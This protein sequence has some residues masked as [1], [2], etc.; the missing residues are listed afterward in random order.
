[1]ESAGARFNGMIYDNTFFLMLEL[2]PNLIKVSNWTG[3]SHVVKKMKTN[4]NLQ[5]SKAV[6]KVGWL[7]SSEKLNL[8]IFC[9][10]EPTYFSPHSATECLVIR[11]PNC[12]YFKLFSRGVY[13][14]MYSW[15][16]QKLIEKIYLTRRKMILLYLWTIL[17]HQ[18]PLS[19]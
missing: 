9:H 1:M 3:V 13:N 8:P 16:Q 10:G 12:H 19:I 4:L 17:P 5:Q 7:V 15:Q 6:S 14:G 11:K 2:S 18:H